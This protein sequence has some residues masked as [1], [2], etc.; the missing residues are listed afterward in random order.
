MPHGNLYA[1][2]RTDL[3]RQSRLRWRAVPV[4]NGFVN[5]FT[6]GSMQYGA[7]NSM[8]ENVE[9]YN[10][11]TMRRY[12][13]G[14]ARRASTCS[15]STGISKP[16]S[17]MA[18]LNITT[19]LEKILITP[20]YNAAID[21]VAGHHRQSGQFPR[22][23]GR[24]RDLPFG[25]GAAR[26][27]ASRSTS[28]ATNTPTGRVPHHLSRALTPTA[29]PRAP[30]A[31]IPGRSSP[32]PGSVRL[33]RFRRC[34]RTGPAK[35]PSPPASSTREEAINTGDR[36]RFARQLRQ[37]RVFDGRATNGPRRQSRC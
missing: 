20:Y 18:K 26:S 2:S 6:A 12:V 28:S 8:L 17:S 10:N 1:P 23:A 34:G 35:S 14:R 24:Q 16:T 30:M 9:N 33:R 4:S 31:A 25:G 22:R 11:R 29:V 3:H 32:P 15:T 7:Q 36:L 19:R 13:V 27:V 21:A 37:P 5:G